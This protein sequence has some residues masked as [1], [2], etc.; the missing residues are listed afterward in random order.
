MNHQARA[1]IPIRQL[2][3]RA[4]RAIQGLEALFHDESDSVAQFL[5]PGHLSF[6]LIVMDE[7]SQLRPEDALGASH[8]ALSWSS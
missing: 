8:A 6:D 1:H 4:G 5:A 2:M 7:A 3:L